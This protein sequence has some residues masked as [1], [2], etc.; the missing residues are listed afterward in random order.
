MTS[1]CPIVPRL[2]LS[3][4]SLAGWLAVI[5]AATAWPASAAV[6]RGALID[7]PVVLT[8]LTMAQIDSLT[9]GASIQSL[10]GKAKCDVKVVSL[11]YQTIGPAGEDTNASGVMLV[12]AGTCTQA[13]VL[14]AYAKGSD[15]EKPHTL[16]S[17]SDS[18]TQGLAA[19]FA[20]QG[21][22]VVATDYL[23][24]AKSNFPYHPYLHADSEASSVIDS[25]RAARNAS[26]TVGANLS[27][28]VMFTGYS[29]GG[30]ASMAAQRAAERDNA[31]EISV[32]AGAHLAGPYNLSGSISSG[33]NFV[34]TQFVVPYFITA[35][36]KVYGN[37]YS[38]VNDVFQTA[39]ASTI[40]ALLPSPTLTLSTLVSTGKLPG[41]NNE[42]PDQALNLLL[43]SAYRT[44]M[45]TNTANAAFVTAKKNDLLDWNPVAKVLLCGG[46]EDPT[47][48]PSIHQTPMKAAFDSRGLTNVTS[49]DVDASI[50]SM[51]AAVLAFAPATYYANYHGTIEPAFC[52]AQAKSFL[53]GVLAASAQLNADADKVF[54]W[55]ER[56][57]PM[58]FT[59]P[60]TSATTGGYRY[61][62]YNGHYLGV[63]ETGTPHLYYLGPL[64]N[65]AVLNLG[66]LS[67]YV[68][69][70]Q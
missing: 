12:P 62:S 54:S 20:G 66:P 25:V 43:Q 26:A 52:L 13:A 3:T 57:F 31:T 42:T 30:H 48:L 53:D 11:N 23:G 46:K 22:V 58:V 40:E 24:F 28:K 55:G 35:W 16:A 45:Q 2:G 68:V 60:A 37:V 15:V 27:G 47:V 44:D 61:R 10:S 5:G 32:I 34:G 41:A 17:S 39:Y 19:F 14:V 59:P 65:N 36:Q 51:F 67:V 21:H 56:T 33:S 8:T 18:Q 49:V 38:N 9:A 7:T 1:S 4:A 69:M 50:R 29:Q 64:N 63:N 6:V 70:A